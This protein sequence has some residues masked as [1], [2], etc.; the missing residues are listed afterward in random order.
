MSV[1]VLYFASLREAMGCDGETIELPV[2]VTTVGELRSFIASRGDASAPLGRMQHLRC[3]INQDMTDWQ[4]A[5]ANGDEVAFFPP[6]TG[7]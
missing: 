4:A 7:G 2:E 5:I 3:A 6:V 1:K